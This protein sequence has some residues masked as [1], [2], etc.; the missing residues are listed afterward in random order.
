MAGAP[1]RST[2]S[3]I[4][5]HSVSHCPL[6]GSIC[7]IQVPNDDNDGEVIMVLHGAYCHK[8]KSPEEDLLLSLFTEKGGKKNSLCF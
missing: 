4:T 1:H 6:E 7:N 2:A 5:S 8:R 3:R